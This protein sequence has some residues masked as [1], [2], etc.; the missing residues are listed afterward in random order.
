LELRVRSGGPIHVGIGKGLAEFA[1][2]AYHRIG[3]AAS[4]VRSVIESWAESV[5]VGSA[6]GPYL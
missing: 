5:R 6:A 3:D 4:V 1:E 2:V